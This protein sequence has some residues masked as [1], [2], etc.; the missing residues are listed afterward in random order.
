MKNRQE[1]SQ[2]NRGARR[3]GHGGHRKGGRRPRL[4]RFL[5]HGDLRFL[6]LKLIEEKPRHGYDVIKAIEERV[7]GAYSPSPGVI[8][9][10]FSL[11]EELEWIRPIDSE[12]SK[13]LFEITEDGSLALRANRATLEAILARMKELSE[14]QAGQAEDKPADEPAATGNRAIEPRL[15]LALDDLGRAIEHRFAGDPPSQD[16]LDS[17]LGALSTAASEIERS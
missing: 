10:T 12:G 6:I 3:R 11:L 16:Q 1:K 4:G 5:A 8:Y 14:A 9:P 2:G 7:A 13:N 17:M 15:R